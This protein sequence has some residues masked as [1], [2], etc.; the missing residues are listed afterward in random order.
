MNN[1]YDN[2]RPNRGLFGL[3]LAWYL[4]AILA[5]V[6]I[7]VIAIPVSLALGWFSTGA[8]VISPENVRTQYAAAYD[9]QNA[10]KGIA[11]NICTSEKARDTE[12]K[13]TEAYTQRSSQVLAQEQNYQRVSTHYNAYVSDPLRA[14]LVRPGDLP[15]VSPT[16]SEMKLIVCK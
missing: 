13:G 8:Q 2:L 4:W 14:K 11:Q 5:V 3:G 6:V 10:L 9:D 16:E 7:T 1:N 15:A 12:I